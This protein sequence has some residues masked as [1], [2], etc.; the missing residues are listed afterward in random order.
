MDLIISNMLICDFAELVGA[1]SADGVELVED[2]RG[3]AQA[4]LR[5]GLLDRF[6][7]RFGGVE[8]DIAPGTLNLAEETMFNRVPLGGIRRIEGDAQAQAQPL[9][10][11]EQVLLESPGASGIAATP[12]AE[13]EHLGGLG[14]AVAKQERSRPDRG[15]HRRRRWC[16][17]TSPG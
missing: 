9:G 8:H 10:Q 3:D 13:H 12:S 17:A 2:A 15:R 16:R 4:G 6:Q 5:G 11:C 7:R 14:A 1:L